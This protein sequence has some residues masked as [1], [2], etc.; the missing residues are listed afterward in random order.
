MVQNNKNT[1]QN[2]MKYINFMSL[3]KFMIDYIEFKIDM[4]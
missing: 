1:K 4:S 2:Q 3:I